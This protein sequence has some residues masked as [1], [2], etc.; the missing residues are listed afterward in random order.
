MKRYMAETFR[1]AVHE[2]A[3]KR[4]HRA[5]PQKQR[6]RVQQRAR[7]LWLQAVGLVD[8]REERRIQRDAE[9]V[10]RDERRRVAS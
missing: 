5:L 7:R 1:G 2:K 9:R 3:A 6:G 4:E 8:K 10:L